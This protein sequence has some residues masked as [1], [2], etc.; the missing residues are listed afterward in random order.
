MWQVVID[1]FT[2][3]PQEWKYQIWNKFQREIILYNHFKLLFKSTYLKGADL[4]G[5]YF[6]FNWGDFNLNY[7]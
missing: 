1:S 2:K 4:K 5:S 3:Y 7:L 6:L